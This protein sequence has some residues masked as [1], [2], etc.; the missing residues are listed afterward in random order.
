MIKRIFKTLVP[1]SF[2]SI[3][4]GYKNIR[5][6]LPH[7]SVIDILLQG[8]IVLPKPKENYFD[9]YVRQLSI[10]IK[11]IKIYSS[12]SY[13]YPFDARTIRLFDRVLI[14]S[15]TVDFNKVLQS[16][17][18]EIRNKLFNVNNSAF[19]KREL[20]II[21]SIEELALRISRELEMSS[22]D[23]AGELS[24]FFPSMLYRKP[25]SLDEAIQKILFYDALFW[26]M[27]HYHIGLG[28]LDLILYEYYIRDLKD[29]IL[30]HK[31]AKAKIKD[32][33]KILG[34]DTSAKSNGLIGDT[35]QY[36]LLGGVD[37]FGDTIDNELTELF[38]E[39]MAELRIP[40]PKLILRVN[41]KTTEKV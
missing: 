4:R 35:G 22:S 8:R 40:D 38:L 3:G 41:K 36:I 37:P 26:Q 2:R 24:S 16:D 28:R 11:K 5:R 14:C 27:E 30:T 10:I 23:R 1:R 21:S 19:A 12:L 17:L 29:G 13:I 25:Q 34:K 15:I 32:L 18:N 9:D 6:K 33:L 31:Q 39:L 20:K 7:L